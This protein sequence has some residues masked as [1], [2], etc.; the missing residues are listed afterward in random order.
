MSGAQGSG[1]DGGSGTVH[2]TDIL[3]L[4]NNGS[5]CPYYFT[6]EFVQSL[7]ESQANVHSN[8]SRSLPGLIRTEVE[9]VS[10]VPWNPP[11]I[12]L[13]RVT[14]VEKKRFRGTPRLT[15]RFS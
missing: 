5:R 6:S 4:N 3:H 14:Q 2:V 10:T 13:S 7:T 11:R 15:G 9:P 1:L 8:P 12:P